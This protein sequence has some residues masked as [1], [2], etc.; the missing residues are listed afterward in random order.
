ME[1][2]HFETLNVCSFFLLV[3]FLITKKPVLLYIS[4]GLIGMSIFIKPLGRVIAD[5]WLKFSYLIGTFNSRI[6]LTLFFF[7][8]LTP[9]AL[10]RRLSRQNLLQLKK[11]N[12]DSYWK[13]VE[14]EFQRD[15]LEKTW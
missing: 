14:K 1:K 10:I 11:G 15:S 6:L 4:F 9:L 7:L 5:S 3:L 2:K 13:K 8:F 12:D